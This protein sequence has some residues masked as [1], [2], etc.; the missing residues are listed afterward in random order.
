MNIKKYILPALAM[1]L[2][3]SCNQEEINTNRH[4]ISDDALR[5]GGLAYGTALMD[6][7]QQLFPI[8]APSE[9]TGPGNDLQ[10]TDLISS[11]N[12]IGYFGNNNNWNFN[13]EASW[14]FPDHR[15]NYIFNQLYTDV[16]KSWTSIYNLAKDSEA[17]ADKQVL[18]LAD[19]IK[20]AAWLRATDAF[21]PIVY[22]TAGDGN[23]TPTPESQ[24]VVYKA[25]LADLSKNVEV[26]KQANRKILPQYDLV[27]DGD[28]KKWIKFANS[29]M[30]RMAV[31]VHF[32]DEALAKEYIAKALDNANGGVIESI[33]DEA[34]VGSS[35]KQPLHNPYIASVEEYGETRMGATIWA[36]LDGFKDPR[37]DKYFI[38]GTRDYRESYAYH[39][40]LPPTADKAKDYSATSY[41]AKRRQASKPRVNSADPVYWYRASETFFLKAEAALYN[42]TIGEAKDFYEMGVKTSF[43]ER[44]L[45]AEQ[46]VAYLAQGEGVQVT[47]LSPMNS[48][49]G[50]NEDIT[51]G[52]VTP[53]WDHLTKGNEVEEKLQKI[54]TQKY[55]ALYP[56]AIEAWTE[57]RRTG[58]PYICKPEDGQAPARIGAK[59]GEL[60]APE[61]F[62]FPASSYTTN[63]NNAVIPSLL[64]GEDQGKTKLWW[65]RPNRP[66]VKY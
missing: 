16:A 7:Q 23:I 19:I 1:A 36:Y 18:A 10:A 15:V 9:T 60:R 31:R 62:R 26:L 35:S 38:P 52:N 20:I 6:M 25:M 40:A 44:G 56:N 63:P 42:L 21:G 13:L 8:G 47:S 64:G 57:Y 30:L 28:A 45:S 11:G 33:A 12:Y 43:A 55:L 66:E 17:P 61:R 54:M 49:S 51:A 65:V 39:W 50:Y 22:T 37:L 53:L 59:Y 46:A 48:L 4:G 24:Q 2:L 34:K 3:S 14:N 41:S 27:Y 58:Y 32:V 5:A 29:I